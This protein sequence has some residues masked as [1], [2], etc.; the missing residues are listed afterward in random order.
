MPI[1]FL[2][3]GDC[4]AVGQGNNGIEASFYERRG[5]WCGYKV[6]LVE[7]SRDHAYA[8]QQCAAASKFAPAVGRCFQ[9]T[10]KDR[11]SWQR[12]ILPVWGYETEIAKEVGTI[13][14]EERGAL[15]TAMN[16]AGIRYQDAHRHNVGRLEDG[17]LVAIDFGPASCRAPE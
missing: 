10:V 13:P 11:T 1:R 4:R 9:G 6:F 16:D 17:T 7:A 2:K 14:S 15:E 8:L 3:N 12:G 5:S